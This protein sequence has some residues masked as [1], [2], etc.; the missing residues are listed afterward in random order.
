MGAPQLTLFEPCDT[1]VA[2]DDRGTI[3]YMPSFISASESAALFQELIREAEWN[4]QRRVMYD[5]ELEVPR[6]TAG[7]VID[8]RE[9]PLPPL[10]RLAARKVIDTLDVSFTSVGLNLYRSG[11]DSVAPH[12]DHLDELRR[13]YP[14]ALL[15]LGAT[16]RMT[17]RAKQPPKR[18]IHIDL[19]AGSLFVMSYQT[20]I[21]YTHGIPK[22][23]ETVGPRVS[24]AF[25]VRPVGETSNR[26]WA[27]TRT[28]VSLPDPSST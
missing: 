11:Q 8:S 12:N 7:Y 15:S 22:T 28:S 16:R 24:L 5:R 18:V 6:L 17:V 20:Q 23:A 21:H 26:Y 25:R 3:A 13:G 4:A 9:K 1:I 19:E 14:I 27:G 2:D 10:L